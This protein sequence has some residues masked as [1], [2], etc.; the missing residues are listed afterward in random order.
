MGNKKFFKPR[1]ITLPVQMMLLKKEYPEAK[2]SLKNNELVWEGIIKPS[3]LSREYNIRILC[4]GVKQ[5]P[6]VILYGDNLEG[7]E[8]KDFPHKFRIDK[9]NKEVKLC[10][11]FFD[12]FKFLQP[13]TDTI[14][15]WIQEWL[16]FYEIWLITDKWYGG[17]HEVKNSFKESKEI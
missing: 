7:L 10:L 9:E 5:R 3:P 11:H 1:I 15:P 14:I 12:E 6:V 17:G 13:I 2:C 8:R 16:Y 4:H